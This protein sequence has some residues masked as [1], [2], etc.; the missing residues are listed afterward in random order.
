MLLLKGQTIFLKSSK[1]SSYAIET[2][3]G[4]HLLGHASPWQYW[5]GVSVN[6]LKY[7]LG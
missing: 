4:K 6:C 1:R 7:C 5:M 3:D 2:T